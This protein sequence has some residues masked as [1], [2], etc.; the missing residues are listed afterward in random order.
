MGKLDLQQANESVTALRALVI[1]TINKANSGHPG[2]A[3]DIAPTLYVLFRNHLVADP[4]NPEWVNRD[5]FVMSSGHVSALLYSMLHVAG[6]GLPMEDLKVFRQLHSITP[7]HPEYGVTK[8]V[9][10][11]SGPLGQGIGQALG[12]AMAEKHIAA[13][14][15]EGSRLMNHYT[16]CLCG[17][18]CLE[19]GISQEAITMAGQYK[20]N[21]LILIYDKNGSTLDGPTSNSLNEDTKLRFKS[22]GWNTLEVK[23]GNEVEEIDRALRKAKK[24]LDKPTII[25]VNTEIGYGSKNQGS[26]KTH[27]SPLGEEDGNQAKAK[28]GWT[29][30]PFE[31]PETVYADFENNLGKRGAR[32]R[33]RW[34]KEFKAYKAE[35][36]AEA[37]VFLDAFARNVKDYLPALPE[38][39]EGSAD[40]SRNTSGKIVIANAANIPFVFGGSADVAASVKTAIPGDPSFSHE[41]PGG[42]NINYGIREFAMATAQNGMLLHGGVVP[43]I[44]CFLVFCD[45][46]KSAIRMAALQNLPAIYLFSHD[47]IAVGED[48]PTHEP[49]EQL[50]SLR[51][52]PGVEVLRP[53]DARETWAA[54]KKALL[55]K[56]HPVCLILSRQNLPLLEK[57]SEKGVFAGGYRVYGKK[58]ADLELLATGS[59]VSLAIGVAK[60][61]EDSGIKAEVISIPSVEAFDAMDEA[62][63]AE[64]LDLPKAK[65]LAFEMGRSGGW[66]RFADTVY[67]IETFGLSAPAKDVIAEFGFTVEKMSEKVLADLK[68]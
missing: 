56:D 11:G 10:A 40:A 45:Y 53:A 58:G 61:L 18:G 30:P 49:I 34:N 38:F 4:K 43:Y 33:R 19:E 25:V 39:V 42:K 37:K 67:G 28:F 31:V 65:R 48:G 12:M 55:T 27:G 44:G 16:Y 52:I 26:C 21:K 5:R 6:Y 15:P 7:G 29:L 22:A 1:D 60:N 63:K 46:M 2:M 3:L 62:Y 13:S 50:W 24:S 17:D 59:E 64:I 36:P 54:W 51:D 9:D 41:H 8:G 23:D 20:L 66:Y 35:H 68:K 32:A 14:Y 47:S 57:S